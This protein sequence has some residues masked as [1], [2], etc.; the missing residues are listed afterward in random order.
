MVWCAAKW[1]ERIA[2]GLDLAMGVGSDRYLVVKFEDMLEETEKSCRDICEFMKIPFSNRMPNYHMYTD[3]WDGKRNY[4]QPIITGNK[5]KWRLKLTRKTI[6]RIEEIALDTMKLFGYPPEYAAK[7]K[8]IHLHEKM[9]GVLHDS[10]AI[11]FVGN[12]AH[13]RNT[14]SHRMKVVLQEIR[15]LVLRREQKKFNHH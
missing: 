7:P 4:G 14:L 13:S 6:K 9:R 8:P 1:A 3:H 5:A 2:K 15:N 11:L 10:W 12:R